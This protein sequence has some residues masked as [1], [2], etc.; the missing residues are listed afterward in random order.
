MKEKDPLLKRRIILALVGMLLAGISVG[1]FKRAFFGVDPFQCFCNGWAQVVPIGFGT[2]YM[3]INAVLLVIDLFLD[4]HYIGIS[5]FINLFLL[6]YVAE[7]TEGMLANML[8]ETGLA[9][10]LLLLVVGI[11]LTCIAAALY[12]TADLGV[13]T[14][15][16]IPLYLADRKY[17]VSGH[18]LPFRV[19]RIACDLLCV[20]IGFLLGWMPGV[21]TIITALFMGPLITF[22]RKRL[23]D[24]LLQKQLS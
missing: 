22:F 24:P 9:V 8:G 3:L 14:Y 7:F 10:R 20:L 21:G 18:I 19:I 5:T 6:G 11:V 16:A 2:L 15:D 23:S 13:S 1:I 12:Y 17:K 4:R